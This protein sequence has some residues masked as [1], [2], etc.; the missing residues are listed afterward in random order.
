MG[1]EN[2]LRRNG[3]GYIDMTAY[4]AI[5]AADKESTADESRFKRLLAVIFYVC[6]NAGFHVENRIELRDKRT[7]KVW[8]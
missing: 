7:G 8:R 4:D 2:D 1:R 6:E 5:Q 3:S